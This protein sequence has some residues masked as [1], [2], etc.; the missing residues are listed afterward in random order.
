MLSI[1]SVLPVTDL[2]LN[3]LLKIA[4]IVALIRVIQALNI[5]IYKNS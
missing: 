5:Y 4:A 3:N 2:V 1:F